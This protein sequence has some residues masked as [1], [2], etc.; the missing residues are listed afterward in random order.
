MKNENNT[1]R[2]LKQKEFE[3]ELHKDLELEHRRQEAQ[4][5]LYKNKNPYV[6]GLI[7]FFGTL[8]LGF[9][10]YFAVRM[11]VNYVTG[12]FLHTV[13]SVLNPVMYVIIIGL[14][15]LAVVRKRSPLDSLFNIWARF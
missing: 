13:F 8:F 5:A 11:G 9:G 12:G 1:Q 4:E 15:V 6:I 7:N 14:A 3:N 2:K 10:F